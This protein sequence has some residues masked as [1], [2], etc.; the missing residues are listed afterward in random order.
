MVQFGAAGMTMRPPGPLEREHASDACK[1][2]VVPTTTPGK[3]MA[4]DSVTLPIVNP[5]TISGASTLMVTFVDTLPAG[6][7]ELPGS[8]AVATNTWVD[9][10]TGR[11][12]LLQ[13]KVAPAGVQRT[14]AGGVPDVTLTVCPAIPPAAVN[15]RFV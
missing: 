13:V 12:P 8:L 7:A 2:P 4:R 14:P 11:P 15:I 1:P 3:I 6:V 10:V 5:L 9:P